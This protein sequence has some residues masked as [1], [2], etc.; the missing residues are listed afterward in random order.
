MA[1]AEI[2]QCPSC[3]HP[4]RVPESL[5]GQPVRC[6]ECK[7]YFAA[8]T[9]AADGRLGEPELL[10]DAPPAVEPAGPRPPG[11]PNPLLV[12]GLFLL[13]V[14]VIGAAVNGYQASQW[15]IDKDAAA[16]DRMERLK[17]VGELIKQPINEDQAKEIIQAQQPTEVVVAALSFLPIFGAIAMLMVRGWV[18]A[19]I[20]S[21]V[22]MIN[23]GN[24]CCLI[25]LPTGIWCL[26]KLFDPQI[27]PLFSQPG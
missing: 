24:C 12:P 19:V 14:G 7:A 9:R 3:R 8:P 6:P 26:V 18:V 17:K 22:A 10:S 21:C 11:A 16:K 25:G 23:L 15:F 13:L 2:I 4:V 20:G 1:S 5:L 27:R